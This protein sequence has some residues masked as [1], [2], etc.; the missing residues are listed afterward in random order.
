MSTKSITSVAARREY[1]RRA[2]AAA[3]MGIGLGYLADLQ[4]RRVI[5]FIRVARKCVL[6]KA[7]DL[8]AALEG[9]KVDRV[10]D[11]PRTKTKG[12]PKKAARNNDRTSQSKENQN[13]V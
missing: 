3:Y 9:M 10:C 13:E 2:E 4:R 12:P 5:P 1:M 11:A 8:D 7:A 6:F